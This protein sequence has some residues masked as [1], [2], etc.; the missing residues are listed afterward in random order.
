MTKFFRHWLL[1]NF[2]SVLG[3]YAMTSFS[4]LSEKAVQPPGVAFFIQKV[5]NDA[6]FICHPRIDVMAKKSFIFYR[7]LATAE[8]FEA[9]KFRR[10]FCLV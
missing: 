6:I 9:S 5:Q 4:K 2:L 7:L 3:D 10:V 8:F 1:I